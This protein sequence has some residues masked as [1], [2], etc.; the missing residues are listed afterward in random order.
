[1]LREVRRIKKNPSTPVLSPA[2]IAALK[3]SSRNRAENKPS[4]SMTPIILGVAFAVF[5]VG[6]VSLFY[7]LDEVVGVMT[8]KTAGVEIPDFSG[9]DRTL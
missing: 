6:V 1:M 8:S 2:R 4:H 7:A 5:I 3:R 9:L